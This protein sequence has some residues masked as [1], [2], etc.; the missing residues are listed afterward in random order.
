MIPVQYPE[1]DFRVK[2]EEGRKWLFDTLRRKW[3][4]LTPEEWVRQNFI[5][6][7]VGVMH[8]PAALI[9]VEKEFRLG[10][11]NKRFD[12]LVYDG[13]H[14]PW[15]MIEC[16]SADVPLDE[17]VLHQLLR[18]QA[19]WPVEYLVI[20]NG[21]HCLGWRKNGGQLEPLTAMPGPKT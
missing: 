1:P 19:A 21:G 5:R 8:Y 15:M 4:A 20:T 14:R 7:L 11:R 17:S 2:Q 13:D 12:I 18:Y 3:V 6:F 9:A 16:K 10:E